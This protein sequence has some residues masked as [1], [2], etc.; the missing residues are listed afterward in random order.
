MTMMTDE[1][2]EPVFPISSLGAFGPGEL[3][4]Q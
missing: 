2:M 4:V 3:K 1:V